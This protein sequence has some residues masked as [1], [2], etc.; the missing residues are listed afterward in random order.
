MNRGRAVFLTAR[1]VAAALGVSPSWFRKHRARLYRDGFPLP[2]R[3]GSTPH[4]EHRFVLTRPRW[5]A[6]DV[7]AFI[8]GEAAVAERDEEIARDIDAAAR[9][10]AAGLAP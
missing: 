5:R 4:P 9:D 8:E 6:A 2:D 3:A 10:I 7:R 1:Q